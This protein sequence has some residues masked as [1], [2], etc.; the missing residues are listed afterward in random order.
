MAQKPK[1]R[2]G[3]A[4]WVDAATAGADSGLPLTHVTK[5]LRAQDVIQA[6]RIE[7]TDCA[8]FGSPLAYFFYGR[9]AYRYEAGSSVKLE[10]ACPFCFIFDPKLLKRARHIY[11]FDTGAFSARMYNHVLDEDFNIEDFDLGSEPERP[12]KLISAAYFSRA[13]YASGNKAGL[14][15]SKPPPRHMTWKRKPTCRCYTPKGVMSLM[16]EL[17]RLRCSLAIQFHWL[18]I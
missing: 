5:G 4:R 12:E 10:S 6:G 11:P 9:P 16:I 2:P 7:P 3:F 17:G 13:E 1:G 18:K 8:V 14:L 15:Q